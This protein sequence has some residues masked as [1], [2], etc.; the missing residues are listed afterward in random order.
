M[1]ILIIP[2]FL[3]LLVVAFGIYKFNFT[4]DD[5]YVETE[6]G[7][8]IPFDKYKANTVL[9]LLFKNSEILAPEN[10]KSVQLTD[11]TGS[12]EIVPESASRGNLTVLDQYSVWKNGLN[13]DLLTVVAVNNGG[14]GTFYYLTLFD[15]SGEVFTKKSEILLGDRIKVTSVGIGELVH[16]PEAEY[17]VSVQ[18]LVRD[19]GESFATEPMVEDTR[20]FYVTKQIL[21]EVEVGRDD[22]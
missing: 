11:G 6:S 12:Y 2:G 5:I 1:K 17:R 10:N 7:E 9:Y 13:T 3:I 8:I 21:E 15:I 18:T 16:D 4:N 14:S 22:T 19:E 20:T